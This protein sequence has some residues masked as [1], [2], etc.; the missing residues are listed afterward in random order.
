MAYRCY[1]GGRRALTKREARVLARFGDKLIADHRAEKKTTIHVSRA[2]PG[3]HDVDVGIGASRATKSFGAYFHYTNH[4]S[5]I[6]I[7]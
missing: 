4:N 6:P 3:S 7:R 1:L 5:R 2:I